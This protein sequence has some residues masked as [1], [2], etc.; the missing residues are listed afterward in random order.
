MRRAFLAVVA[1]TLAIGAPDIQADI[2]ELSDGNILEG[3]FV[4]LSGSTLK[5]AAGGGTLVITVPTGFT[6]PTLHPGDELKLLVSVGA[7][8][9][10]TLAALKNEEAGDNQAEDDDD[11]GVDLDEDKE[12]VEV[13]GVVTSIGAT[14]VVQPGGNASKYSL[15]DPGL[16]GQEIA[17]M[18]DPQLED[19]KPRH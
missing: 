18:E 16:Q 2:I 6:L 4:E 7:N 1:A 15:P 13:K 14:I 8:N 11:Q 10:F 12:E 5:L 19:R 9:S 17:K 3:K